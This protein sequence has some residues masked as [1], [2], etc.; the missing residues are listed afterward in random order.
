MKNNVYPP[1]IKNYN[2]ATALRIVFV[3]HKQNQQ[4]NKIKKS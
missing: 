3:Q 1:S 4:L 2:G